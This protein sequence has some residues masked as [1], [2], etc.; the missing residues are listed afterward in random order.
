MMQLQI[1]EESICHSLKNEDH[2]PKRE[3]AFVFRNCLLP[4]NASSDLN[5]RSPITVA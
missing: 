5:D 4:L 2:I 1:K 3:P